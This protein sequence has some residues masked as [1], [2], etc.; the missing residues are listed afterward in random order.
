MSKRYPEAMDMTWGTVALFGSIGHAS[1]HQLLGVA[2][3]P[4][5]PNLR[6]EFH[7]PKYPDYQSP[8]DDDAQ[9]EILVNKQ[10]SN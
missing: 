9:L 5:E 8:P 2:E 4:A 6:D 3:I 1:G 7:I 10:Y